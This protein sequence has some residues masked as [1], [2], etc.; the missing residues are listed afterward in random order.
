MTESHDI[1]AHTLAIGDKLWRRP[2]SSTIPYEW[3]EFNIVRETRGTWIVRPRR[4]G[5]LGSGFRN[6]YAVNK[7]TLKTARDPSNC[8]NQ[9]WFYTASGVANFKFCQAHAR[10]LARAVEHCGNMTTLRL[11]AE[12]V[13][14]E[15]PRS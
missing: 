15:V 6:E 3:T 2:F 12:L 13:G 9:D 14:V 10:A 8:N 4:G 11:V 7:K 5:G 1:W